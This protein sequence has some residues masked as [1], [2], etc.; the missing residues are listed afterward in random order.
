[1]E[2]NYLDKP[3]T[4]ELG[5]MAVIGLITSG[6]DRLFQ[7]TCLI[8]NK[9][10]AGTGWDIDLEQL[11]LLKNFPP[12]AGNKGMFKGCRNLSFRNTSGCLGAF[13]LLDA[14]GEMMVLAASLI[15]DRLGGKKSLSHSD[16]S[17][18]VESRQAQGD[19]GAWGWHFGSLFMRF[20]PDDWHFLMEVFLPRSGFPPFIFSGSGG[21]SFLGNAHV[22]RD[23][24]DFVRCWT[25]FSLGEITC[26]QNTV[27]NRAVDAFS[28]RLIQAAGFGGIAAFPDD[29]VLAD[30]RIEGR[31]AVLVSHLNVEAEG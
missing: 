15:S 10:R 5:D 23:I 7:R 4:K 11:F 8:Q 28:N 27:T 20:H 2:F 9:R 18:A 6:K 3:V 19:S 31:L 16:L 17:H 29:N 14:P 1:V 26:V 13:G 22:C 24:Y 30:L 25:Q 12:F 21:H